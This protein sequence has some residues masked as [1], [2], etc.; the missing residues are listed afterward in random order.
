MKTLDPE[1]SSS[2][3]KTLK[4]IDSFRLINTNMTIGEVVT[5]LE[6]AKAQSRDSEACLNV[7]D[8]SRIA[9]FPASTSSRYLRKLA[10]LDKIPSERSDALLSTLED[11]SDGRLKRFKL[12]PRGELLINSLTKAMS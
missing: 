9:S 2:I 7:K 12:T 3:E 6:A 8:L 11:Y 4:A 10:L 1:Q 5:I